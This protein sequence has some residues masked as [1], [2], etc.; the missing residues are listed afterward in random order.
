MESVKK[1]KEYEV[2]KKRSGRFGVIGKDGMWVRADEKV[3][4]LTKEGLIKLTPA[5]KKE[6]APAEAPAQS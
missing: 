1:N 4:I 5:K 6:E 3:K 2:V